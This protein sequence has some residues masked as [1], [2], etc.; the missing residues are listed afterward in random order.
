MRDGSRAWG[1]RP[2]RH[3]VPQ[4]IAVPDRPFPTLLYDLQVPV[5]RTVARLIGNGWNISHLSGYIADMM[6]A[7]PSLLF[8]VSTPYA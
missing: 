4:F 1:Q 8:S 7:G 6:E 2:T 3:I 5:A